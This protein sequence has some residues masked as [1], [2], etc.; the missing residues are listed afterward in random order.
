MSYT[1]IP[2]LTKP[3]A[4]KQGER[5][6]R[7]F[8]LL[9]NAEACLTSSLSWAQCSLAPWLMRTNTMR[10]NRLAAPF[11]AGFNCVIDSNQGLDVWQGAGPN[12]DFSTTCQCLQALG[13][14]HHIT[15]DCIFH[16]LLGANIAHDG[17]ATV[18]ANANVQCGLTTTLARRVETG[19]STLHIQGHLHGP[20]WMIR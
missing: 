3:A 13:D 7:S 14:V 11:D 15:Y 6:Q 20:L 2:C 8:A 18:N 12:E 17:F 5:N 16:T 10:Q 1:K 19:G 9:C 4:D